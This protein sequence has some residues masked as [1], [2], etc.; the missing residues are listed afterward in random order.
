L[1]FD[2][3]C[4]IGPRVEVKAVLTKIVNARGKI[5]ATNTRIASAAANVAV[6]IQWSAIVAGAFVASALAFVLHSFA[7]ATGISVSSTAPTWRDASMAL[8]LL[9][10]LYLVLMALACYGFGAYLVQSLPGTRPVPAVVCATAERNFTHY[11]TG[12]NR[13]RDWNPPLPIPQTVCRTA[14]NNNVVK[15]RI[16]ISSG[17]RNIMHTKFLIIRRT[18]VA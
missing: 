8:V 1:Y 18:F 12:A 2:C 10:G 14:V 17:P 4:I 6:D 5:V 13:C 11:G 15:I 16:Y 3:S 9:S 7:G